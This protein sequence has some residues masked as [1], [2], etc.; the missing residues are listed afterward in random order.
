[1]F[2]RDVPRGLHDGGAGSGEQGA[3]ST[4]QGGAS[5]VPAPTSQLPPPT[6]I[7]Q[8]YLRLFE[9]RQYLLTCIGYAMWTF[10]LGGLGVWTP[11]FMQR[12]RG[13]SLKDSTLTFGEIVLITGFVGT[14][15]GGWLSDYFLKYTKE[16]YLWLC[17]I[18]SLLAA[19][20]TL[21]AFNHPNKSVWLPAM[22]AAEVLVFAST[23]PVNSAI[24]NL[25]A[26][27]QRATALAL[28]IL[29]MHLLGDVPSPPL[30]GYLSDISSLQRAFLVVPV[31][32][33]AGGVIWSYAAWR[34][35]RVPA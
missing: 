20:L 33:F 25:V 24:V 2:V 3:G 11:A 15:A 32:I 12:V 30:I 13:M 23:G 31:A 26:P 35:T 9:N 1:M 8:S 19:P 4:E 7:L 16:S 34:G 10:A 29:L 14:F 6:S 22:V 27:G 5:Q 28:S 18:T 17:G 21:I